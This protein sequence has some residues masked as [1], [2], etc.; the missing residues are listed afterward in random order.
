MTVNHL[1][2]TG[3]KHI[4]R[5]HIQ[6]ALDEPVGREFTA[7]YSLSHYSFPESAEVII[8]AQVGWTVQ[9][10]TFGTI[11]EPQNPSDTTLSE[12]GSTAGL[13]FRLKVVEA[14]GQEGMILGEADRIR[15]SGPAEEAG[16]QSFVVVRP[17]D[18][19]DVVWR[20]IFDEGQP[21]LLV[22]R[23]IPDYHSFLRRREI[24][25]LIM[26][27]VLRQVLSE[28]IENEVELEDG[29]MWQIQAIQLASSLVHRLPPSREDEEELDE[30]VDE[31]VRKFALKHRLFRGIAL[32]AEPVEE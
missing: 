26:P 12:F 27:E 5:K 18:L 22:N 17:E 10:F 1:N 30:W 2:F 24:S 14:G 3:R 8:E 7:S 29:F 21:L 32:D 16:Q 11:G 28:A 6:I 15:P 31:V 20:V 19:G 9:R 13:L 23:R 25:G 4:S